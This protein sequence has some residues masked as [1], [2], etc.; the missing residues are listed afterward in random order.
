M[1]TAPVLAFPRF[2]SD[3]RFILDTDWSHDTNTIGGVLSQVQDGKE[4]VIAYGAK[5]LPASAKR[6][7]PHKG[8]LYAIIFFIRYWR[9][10]IEKKR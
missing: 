10:S 5:K 1:V 9:N 7:A 4:R 8:E 3:Q 2:D 6:Y